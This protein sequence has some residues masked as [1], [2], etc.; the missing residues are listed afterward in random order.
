[1]RRKNNSIQSVQSQA[2][3]GFAKRNSL[4]PAAGGKANFRPM[5]RLLAVLVL[6]LTAA[7]QGALAEEDILLTTITPDGSG[8][9]V[10]S[11]ANIATLDNSGSGYSSSYGWYSSST[12]YL[13]VTAAEGITITKVK[14]TTN[15]NDSCEDTD[16]PFQVQLDGYYVYYDNKFSKNLTGDG[17]TKIEVYGNATPAATTYSVK[18][19]DA[20]DAEA[21][22]W[23]IA[24]GGN[25]VTGNVAEGL[26][27]LSEGDALTLTYSG[28]KRVKSVKAVVEAAEGGKAPEGAIGGTVYWNGS[29]YQNGGDT[30]LKQDTIVYP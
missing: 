13:T 22:N 27:G 10:Y 21:A 8:N 23:T 9:P 14:F 24:S 20:T 30:Y 11:V 29:A 18:M 26:T 12:S 25:S 5:A 16:A 19:A 2:G 1:M 4:R 7:V 17:V 3:P 6:L 28:N 15:N